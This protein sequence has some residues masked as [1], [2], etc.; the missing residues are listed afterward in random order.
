MNNWRV[1]WGSC[2]EHKH[3]SFSMCL[4]C[5]ME[6]FYLASEFAGESHKCWVRTQIL[7]EV[8]AQG[9]RLPLSDALHFVGER[10]RSM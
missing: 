1:H 7:L 3:E 2:P 5:L 8:A 4:R 9:H 6:E 10:R